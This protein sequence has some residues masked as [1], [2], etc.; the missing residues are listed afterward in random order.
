MN[1]YYLNL[2]GLNLV[3]ESPWEITV[4][5]RIRPFLCEKPSSPDCCIQILSC[6]TLP[7]MG[8]TGQWHAMAWYEQNP[9]GMQIFH[10]DKAGG[11]PFGM[12]RLQ[13]D[14]NVTLWVL[15]GCEGY[16]SGTA[17]IFNRIGLEAL[18]LQHEALLLHS[19]LVR[20]GDA[21]IAF[22]GPS[23]VGKSTQAALWQQHLGADI[24]NGD[25][26]VLRSQNGK[27][28]G[29]GSPYAGTSGIYRNEAAPV[30][31]LVVLGQAKE[32]TLLKI[33]AMQALRHCWS[34]LSVHRWDQRFVEKSMDLFLR[35]AQQIPIYQ[36]SCR[37]DREAVLL[38]KEE[39]GL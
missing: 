4:S 24:L 5:D 7:E 16:F 13:P 8:K 15:E 31:A 27:W 20:F 28:I 17:G 36:L 34:E 35:F 2:A 3:L 25:R 18:L 1:A 33:T 21:A 11:T 14:G 23:G 39:L 6:K 26:T 9:L 22:A 30:R 12:T 37:P 32:N 38:L 29:Y 10:C 19:S